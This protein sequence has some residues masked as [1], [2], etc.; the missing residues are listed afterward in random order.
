MP[1]G[2]GD[3][4]P[5]DEV[6]PV[7]RRNLLAEKWRLAMS[8]AG[9]AFA[10]L[11]ILIIVSLYRGWSGASSLF[12]ELP[13]D[14]WVAQAGT[15]DPFRAASLLPA[16]RLEEL[17]RIEGV[18]AVIPVYAR[19]IGFEDSGQDLDVFFMSLAATSELPLAGDL[20]ERFFPE[21]GHVIIDS[22]L[23][24]EAGLEV[25][26]T[27]QVL[28]Q[29]L[30]VERI[31]PGGNP[32]FELGF[33]NGADVKELVRTDDYV[34]FFLLSAAP[35][36]DLER[37]AAEAAAAVPNAQTST[38]GEFAQAMGELVNQGFLPVVSVLVALGLVIGGAVIALTTYTA[39]I[40]KARDFG[41]LKAVGASNA[42]V[43]RIVLVQ[44]LIVG[45]IGSAIGVVASAFA[46]TLIKRGVPEF[47]TEL[48]WTDALGIFAAALVVSILAAYV[49]VHRIN[50][51]DPAMVFRA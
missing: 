5:E 1:A 9:V 28:G 18:Q 16:D 21:A 33:L 47:V 24:Q 8:I 34:N 39:T 27:L 17:A 23:A 46:A 4:D 38:S 45:V 51:I 6:V 36:A 43:Y 11:L 29:P 13:G 25:G 20:R 42:F 48:R 2:S 10:V 26:D 44:S 22:V 15:T 50:R 35:G 49:P 30:V 41:V 7:A 12:D 31:S 3:G 32:I 40:E 14:L 19:R 37:I